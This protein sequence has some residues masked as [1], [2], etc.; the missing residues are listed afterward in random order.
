VTSTTA[1]P[2]ASPPLRVLWTRTLSAWR[3][4]YAPSMGAALA[5]YTLFSLAPL[6]LTAMA[7]GGWLFGREVAN[8]EVVAQLRGLM[9]E[10]GAQ[11]VQAMLSA[12]RDP[13]DSVPMALLGVALTLLGAATVFGELQSTLDRIWQVPHRGGAGALARMLRARLRSFGMV[14]GAGL[15]LLASLL[16]SAA[17]ARIGERFAESPLEKLVLHG[18]DLAL[19]AV[20]TTVV[21]A[22]IYKTVPSA[23]IAWRDVAIGAIATAVLFS[24]GRLLLGLYLG[25]SGISSGFGAAGSL[26]ALLVWLHYSAQIFLLGAEF[27]WVYANACGSRRVP[28]PAQTTGDPA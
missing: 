7:L 12:A 21:F 16:A 11:A 13:A 28:S 27:T 15:V 25:R 14:L 10:A 3:S 18:A 5:F 17:L 23:R 9:G 2:P 22:A 24:L 4:D 1:T 6:L 20:L 19:G 26:A 8:G